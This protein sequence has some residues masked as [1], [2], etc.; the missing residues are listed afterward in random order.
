V[1]LLS[2]AYL[3][4]RAAALGT[5]LLAGF[6]SSRRP[7]SARPVLTVWQ[8]AL[9]RVT[10][11]VVAGVLF[12]VALPLWAI[13]AALIKLDSRGPVFFVQNRVGENGRVFKCYKFRTMVDG[14][15]A[16]P[17][18]RIGNGPIGASQLKLPNDPRRTRVGRWLRRTSLDETPQFL[19][20]LKGEMSLIGPRPEEVAIVERYN[21]WHRRRL[22]LKPGMSGPTQING[23]GAL[24][25]DER[26]RL[27][28][29]YIEN[30]SLRADLV[31]IAKT[32]PAVI[33]SEGS[34]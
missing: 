29:E 28:L 5:G 14:A 25:L 1:G 30:Y 9:K 8:R 17:V 11:L 3:S 12:V 24:S 13:I 15:E 33:S 23:R 26:V 10:D 4:I 18:N 2:A 7:S 20:V 34:Y 16:I 32:I 27:E 6:L 19:N 31:M 22:A 21:D